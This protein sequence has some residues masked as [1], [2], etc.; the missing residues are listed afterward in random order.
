MFLLGFS[1]HRGERQGRNVPLGVRPSIRQAVAP[2]S[3]RSIRYQAP[4][5]HHDWPARALYAAQYSNCAGR[6]WS[7]FLCHHISA[8]GGARI[9]SALEGRRRGVEGAH[10]LYEFAGLEGA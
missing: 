3:R 8:R 4:K 9:L 1:H 6:L 5:D 10:A 2:R 7:I